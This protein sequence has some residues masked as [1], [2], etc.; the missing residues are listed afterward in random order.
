MKIYTLRIVYNDKTGELKSLDEIIEED[1]E[2]IS[3]TASPHVMEAIAKADLIEQL[4]VSHP[5]ESV[6]EAWPQDIN[7]SV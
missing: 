2:P 5:G 7:A 3:I 4:L 6:G 1:E